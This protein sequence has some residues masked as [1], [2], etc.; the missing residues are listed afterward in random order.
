M[1]FDRTRIAFGPEAL[2]RFTQIIEE[3]ASELV[4]DGVP[5]AR[6]D[7]PKC[8]QG[9]PRDYSAWLA[10]GGQILKLSSSC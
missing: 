4:G 3:V 5:A 9:W 10:S 7:Q 2:S 1:A 8:A 6:C